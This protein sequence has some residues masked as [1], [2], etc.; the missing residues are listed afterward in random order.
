MSAGVQKHEA[1]LRFDSAVSDPI[2][3]AGRN[4]GRVRRVE[5]EAFECPEAVRCRDR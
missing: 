4:L 2:N 1:L 5:Y 3:H